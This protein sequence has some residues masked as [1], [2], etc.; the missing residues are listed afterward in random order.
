MILRLTVTTSS[1]NESRWFRVMRTWTTTPWHDRYRLSRAAQLD[2]VNYTSTTT[3]TYM[4]RFGSTR[5]W[6][7]V[8][9]SFK[10]GYCAGRRLHKVKF[11]LLRCPVS[12]CMLGAEIEEI[13][14]PRSRAVY[15]STRAG[16]FSAE[17][18]LA[19]VP[20]LWRTPNTRSFAR[21][22]KLRQRAFASPGS[23]VWFVTYAKRRQRDRPVLSWNG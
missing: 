18:R 10:L 3:T 2:G 20:V 21:K 23:C 15:I 19:S 14:R 11:S 7:A 6:F 13:P 12:G 8:S 9:L 22:V 5:R 17:R 1:Q 16:T 4:E